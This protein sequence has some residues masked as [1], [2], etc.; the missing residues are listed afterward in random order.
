MSSTS[1]ERA[2]F[3][4]L[5]LLGARIAPARCRRVLLRSAAA[6]G[7]VGPL[8][9]CLEGPPRPHN[10]LVWERSQQQHPCGGY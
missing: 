6:V 9:H 1:P 5:N 3:S 7:V 2:S 10:R 8:H 4:G